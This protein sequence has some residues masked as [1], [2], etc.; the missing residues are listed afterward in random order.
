MD[1]RGQLA[2]VI[3]AA[4]IVVVVLIVAVVAWRLGEDDGDDGDADNGTTDN[5]SSTPTPPATNNNTPVNNTTVNNTNVTNTTNVSVPAPTGILDWM[6]ERDDVSG[7]Y[8]CDN[9]TKPTHGARIYTFKTVDGEKHFSTTYLES[10]KITDLCA[11]YADAGGGMRYNIRW[12]WSTVE[13]VDGY[14]LYQYYL[15]NVTE[16]NYSFYADMTADA[17][18]YT[19][20]GLRSWKIFRG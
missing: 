16:R 15:L 7:G 3:I 17:V 13:G 14:R 20:T 8:Y 5:D 9:Y 10:T 19:E 18:K 6:E 4:L 2:L 1:K 12:L 11:S